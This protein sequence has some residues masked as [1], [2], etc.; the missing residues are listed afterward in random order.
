[1]TLLSSECLDHLGRNIKW[2]LCDVVSFY[3]GGL[4]SLKPRSQVGIIQWT[5]N[6]QGKQAGDTK[7]D[8]IGEKPPFP[9]LAPAT[10]GHRRNDLGSKLVRDACNPEIPGTTRKGRTELDSSGQLGWKGTVCN[11]AF[12]FSS[13]SSMPEWT[14][15]YHAR[16][17]H[18][19]IDVFELITK[20]SLNDMQ[21]EQRLW[22]ASPVPK[23]ALLWSD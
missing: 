20:I 8:I 21:G 22:Q 15:R 3:F 13:R 18:S 17:R 19:I 9:A 2:N 11:H 10:A 7:E 16:C 5:R 6:T 23:A 1:M 12:F 4:R 14:R